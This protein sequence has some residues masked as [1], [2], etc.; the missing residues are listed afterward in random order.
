MSFHYQCCTQ[1]DLTTW[2]FQ[3]QV[4]NRTRIEP[5]PGGY[6]LHV[7]PPVPLKSPLGSFHLYTDFQR[8]LLFLPGGTIGKPRPP[9]AASQRG[10]DSPNHSASPVSDDFSGYEYIGAHGE[11]VIYPGRFRFQQSGRS[12]F[13]S[14]PYSNPPQYHPSTAIL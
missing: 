2:G 14:A 6:V 10:N 9:H 11:P 7:N 13:F 4:Y 8:V 5:C 1:Q 12:E 3:E